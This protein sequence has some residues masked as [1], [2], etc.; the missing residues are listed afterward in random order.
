[1]LLFSHSGF[2]DTSAVVCSV[3]TGHFEMLFYTIRHGL[4]Y[5]FFSRLTYARRVGAAQ[6]V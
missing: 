2:C 1:M 6:K 3:W 5:F 4:K